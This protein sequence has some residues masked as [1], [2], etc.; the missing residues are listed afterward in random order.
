[1]P[2]ELGGDINSINRDNVLEDLLWAYLGL[3]L[4]TLKQEKPGKWLAI[5]KQSDWFGDW[6]SITVWKNKT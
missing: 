4:Q 6:L 5:L 2:S 3:V 1:M